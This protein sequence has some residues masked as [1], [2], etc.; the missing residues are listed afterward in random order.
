VYLWG[1]Q[2]RVSRV[3]STLYS[4]DCPLCDLPNAKPVPRT[5]LSEPLHQ[6]P[7]LCRG[8]RGEAIVLHSWPC[9]KRSS[10]TRRG[11]L[12]ISSESWRIAVSP[13]STRPVLCW[14][15]FVY[16]CSFVPSIPFLLSLLFSK[17]VDIPF[18]LSL[19]CPCGHCA[20]HHSLVPELSLLSHPRSLF[21]AN[22][23]CRP[24]SFQSIVP[25]LLPIALHLSNTSLPNPTINRHSLQSLY[26]PLVQWTKP[27]P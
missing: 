20:R 12:W 27:N 10:G 11:R 19:S 9:V 7:L 13:I 16:F 22:P 25:I 1:L 26:T 5:R 14:P 15:N 17:A 3:D 18:F 24:L 4:L 8:N 23:R 6:P 2:P 21:S